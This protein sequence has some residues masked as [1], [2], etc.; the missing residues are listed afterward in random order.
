MRLRQRRSRVRVAAPWSQSFEP[1]FLALTL[2]AG[3]V[4]ARASRYLGIALVA[5]PWLSLA[6]IFSTRPG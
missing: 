4:Y 6:R 5:A 1:L 3:F 2:A